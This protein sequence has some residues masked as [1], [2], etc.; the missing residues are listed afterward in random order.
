MYQSRKHLGNFV[1]YMIVDILTWYNLP[2]SEEIKKRVNPLVSALMTP[3]HLESDYITL[4]LLFSKNEYEDL[5]KYE[6]NSQP[7]SNSDKIWSCLNF[8]NSTYTKKNE[9]NY[10]YSLPYN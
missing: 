7:F 5:I 1:H 9:R 3:S 10:D 6:T 4:A 2:L 8:M